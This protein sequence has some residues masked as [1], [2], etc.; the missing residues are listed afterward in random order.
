M[1]IIT[2]LLTPFNEDLSVDYLSL[3]NLL[4]FQNNSLSDAL[5]LLGTTSESFTLSLKE[6][7]KILNMEFQLYGK[8]KII[9]IEGN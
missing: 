2:A 1:R 5:L 3:K 6:K 9:N 4:L 7:M 8:L